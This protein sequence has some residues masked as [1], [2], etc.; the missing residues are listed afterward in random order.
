MR[1]I[2]EST[3]ERLYKLLRRPFDGDRKGTDVMYVETIRF[4]KSAHPTNSF[5]S[6][7]FRK[8]PQF[9]N[10]ARRQE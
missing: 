2:R 3:P 6:R 7:W 10:I 5:G 9:A 4:Q 8:L 1:R